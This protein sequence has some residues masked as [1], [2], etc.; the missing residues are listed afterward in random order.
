[1]KRV[2]CK[3]LQGVIRSLEAKLMFN[4]I[5]RAILMSYFLLATVSMQ[6]FTKVKIDDSVEGL[7]NL[8]V[9]ILILTFLVLFPLF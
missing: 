8:I 5:L 1:M 4:S 7:V 6:S 9:G 2:G 3:C